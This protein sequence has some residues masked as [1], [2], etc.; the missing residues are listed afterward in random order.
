MSE[1]CKNYLKCILVWNGIN[2]VTE[3]NVENYYVLTVLLI[4]ELINY[5]RNIIIAFTFLFP[6]YTFAQI[7]V[8]LL[9]EESKKI[10]TETLIN[11]QKVVV[12]EI[13]QTLN[14]SNWDNEYKYTYAYDEFLRKNE[15]LEQSWDGSNWI[16]DSNIKF[17]YDVKNNVIEKILQIWDG[18]EWL[19]KWRY[20]YNYDDLN[21]MIKE[22]WLNWNN[23]KWNERYRFLFYYNQA[24]FINK[25]QLFLWDGTSW[26]MDWEVT[27]KYDENG[28]MIEE[29]IKSD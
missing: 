27:Y 25:Q 23:A 4:G 2:S 22:E 17:S 29:K 13:Y 14:D 1:N 24:N 28:N 18:V 3:I 21:N 26:I 6:Y 8:E 7:S 19:N 16:N 5:T 11:N 20:N 9:S 10:I 15:T 12:K